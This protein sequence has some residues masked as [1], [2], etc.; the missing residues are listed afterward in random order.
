MT[1]SMQIRARRLETGLSLIELMVAL[2]IGLLQLKGVL[3]VTPE[4]SE[5]VVEYLEN[6][7]A[8]L[9]QVSWPDVGIAVFTLALLVVFPRYNKKIPAPLIGLAA[10][11][12]L[13]YA[14]GQLI[15]GFPAGTET[16]SAAA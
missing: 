2:V 3:G 12:L 4:Q 10:A 14:L 13:A 15:D 6:L 7:Y 9:G 8:V 5:G 1:V 16:R 11:G